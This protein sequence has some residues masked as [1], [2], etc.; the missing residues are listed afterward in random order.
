[1]TL[2]RFDFNADARVAG[3]RIAGSLH[4]LDLCDCQAVEGSLGHMLVRQTNRISRKGGDKEGEPM[5][6]FRVSRSRPT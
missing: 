4:S 5:W 6:R 1:M 3:I 2:N